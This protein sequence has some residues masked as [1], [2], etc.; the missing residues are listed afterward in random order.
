MNAVQIT[1]PQKE[2]K[3]TN[4]DYLKLLGL[5]TG[6][7]D[8]GGRFQ[9][10]RPF[11]SGGYACGTDL[12]SLCL[13]RTGLVRF[14][15]PE[16]RLPDVTRLKAETQE[17]FEIDV[18]R[19]K[20][21]G[22]EIPMTE[23]RD[24]TDGLCVCQ[25]GHAHPCTFCGGTCKVEEAYTVKIK[26]TDLQVRYLRLIAEAAAIVGVSTVKC[27]LHADRPEDRQ[28]KFTINR[29]VRVLVMPVPPIRVRPHDG[30]PKM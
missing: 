7:A 22:L 28:V 9:I 30:Y 11:Y 25:C 8:Q 10:S 23:C 5:F 19:L 26:T 27:E 29:N 21:A 12:I 14:E 3:L 13:I 16:G 15:Q 2:K 24:C 18:D 4:D 6:R 1:V 20:Y 17:P